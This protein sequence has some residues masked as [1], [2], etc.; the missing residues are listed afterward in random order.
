[1]I[2]IIRT[3]ILVLPLLGCVTMGKLHSLSVPQPPHLV[4]EGKD[5]M[6]SCQQIPGLVPHKGSSQHCH[7][8]LGLLLKSQGNR[9]SLCSVNA[10]LRL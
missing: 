2:Q 5:E 1:M 6:S 9:A 3:Q 8:V 4:N 10:R 7:S